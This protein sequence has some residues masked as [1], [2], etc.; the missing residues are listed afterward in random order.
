MEDDDRPDCRYGSLCYQ[1]NPEH[2]AKFKHSFKRKERNSDIDISQ[3]KKAKKQETKPRTSDSA[4]S[5]TIPRHSKSPQSKVNSKDETPENSSETSKPDT[6]ES[7]PSDTSPKKRD[8]ESVKRNSDITK[9]ES[10]SGNIESDKKRDSELNSNRNSITSHEKKRDSDQRSLNESKLEES[11]SNETT[12]DNLPK[13]N[14]DR[15]TGNEVN[16]SINSVLIEDVESDKKRD[17]ELNSNRNII[18]SHEKKR[19]SDQRSLNESKLEESTSNET[20]EDN[21]PKENLDRSTGNEVNLSINSVLI[22]DVSHLKNLVKEKYLVHMPDE[23]FTFWKLCQKIS[24][25]CPINAFKSLDLKLV[26]PFDIMNGQVVDDGLMVTHWRYFYDPP[27]FQT[28]IVSTGKDHLH[29][30]YFRD[31]PDEAPVF[32]ASNSNRDCKINPVAP[33][34]FI[35]INEKLNEK[36]KS[37]DLASSPSKVSSLQQKLTDFAHGHKIDLDAPKLSS[38]VR[39][40]KAKTVCKGLSGVGIVV[41]Y[42]KKTELGYRPLQKSDKDLETLFRQYKDPSVDTRGKLKIKSILEEVS[43]WVTIAIDESDFGTGL[44]FGLDLF[45]SG[46]EDLHSM[47]KCTLGVAYQYLYRNEFD[48]ILEAHLENRNVDHVNLLEPRQ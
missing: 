36:V 38:V 8:S 42:V 28:I 30:G 12:E 14:L 10:V 19:D 45:G 29:F 24:P 6:K 34:I 41:P 2:H 18:T 40:R 46:I 13:E 11:T 43:T 1:K 22:E 26:G 27:E 25:K 7:A 39:A 48:T 37:A 4:K 44:E 33:N 35:F 15:S 16:L 32:I 23:F 3:N 20:T 17:S 5:P 31:C 47:T 9:R 21:L